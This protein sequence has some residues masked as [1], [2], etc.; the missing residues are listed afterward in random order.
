MP[1]SEETA[2]QSE[3]VPYVVALDEIEGDDAEDITL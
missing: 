1:E 2:S 3:P